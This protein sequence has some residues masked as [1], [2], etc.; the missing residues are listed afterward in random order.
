M[1]LSLILPKSYSQL[2]TMMKLQRNHFLCVKEGSMK[3]NARGRFIGIMGLL[4]W[5]HQYFKCGCNLC[6][7]IICWLTLKENKPIPYFATVNGLW[8]HVLS[9]TRPCSKVWPVCSHLTNTIMCAAKVWDECVGLI[10]SDHISE[11]TFSDS[12]WAKGNLDTFRT[13]TCWHFISSIL[14]SAALPHKVI[15][16]RAIVNH[17]PGCQSL[18]QVREFNSAPVRLPV[19]HLLR[20]KIT[21]N[22]GGWGNKQ[23]QLMWAEHNVCARMSSGL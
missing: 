16:K 17:C 6:H 9:L 1:L 14:D 15:Y 13:V 7:T 18:I 19:T 21:N 8:Y 12:N 3:L 22:W 20:Y 11:S 10:V 23:Q 4:L 2:D 5:F